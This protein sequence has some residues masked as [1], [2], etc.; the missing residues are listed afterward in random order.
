MLVV[1]AAT[2]LL[3]A[4][5]IITAGMS[6]EASEPPT[7]DRPNVVLIDGDDV[8]Y[9]DLGCSGATAAQTPSLD[10]LAASGLRFTDAHSSSATGTR[11]RSR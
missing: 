10:A 6:P 1:A 4:I 11:G 8:G 7:S 5:G 9:G 2:L 3:V